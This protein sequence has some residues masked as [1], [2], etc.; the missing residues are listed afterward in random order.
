MLPFSKIKLR[1]ND[2]DFVAK[3]FN[4][5]SASELY[6]ILKARSQIFIVEQN[7]NYN[8]MDDVDYNSMHCF[9]KDNNKIVAYLRAFCKDDYTVKIGRV[10]TIN[11][12]NGLGR[13]LMEDS[14][15]EIKNKLNCRKICVDAQKHAVGYYRRFGFNAVSDEF[16]EEGIVHISMELNF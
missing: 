5:L 12:G 13:K 15:V 14:I 2:M 1:G 3:K 11:H 8:D 9:I 10:L 7:I 4:E 16:L 6:E